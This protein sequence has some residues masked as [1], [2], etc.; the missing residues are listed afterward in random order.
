MKNNLIDI[1]VHF[2]L[3]LHLQLHNFKVIGFKLIVYQES[4]EVQLDRLR[5]LIVKTYTP[6]KYIISIVVIVLLLL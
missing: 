3:V 2:S 6:S 1:S 4:S 5:E